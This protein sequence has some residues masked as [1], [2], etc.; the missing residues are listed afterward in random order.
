MPASVRIA[1]VQQTSVPGDVEANVAA[2]ADLIG[3]AARQGAQVVLFPELS[4]TGYELELVEQ[5]PGLTLE[6]GDVRID[7]LIA[8]C[9]EVE[10]IAIVG[11]PVVH[12][13]AR[14]LAALVLDGDGVRDVYGKRRVHSSESHLFAPGEHAVTLEVGGCRL[15]LAVCA[16]SREPAHAADCRAAGADAYLVGAFHVGGE[17]QQTAKRMAARARELGL[18]VALAEH[19]GDTGTGTGSACGGSGFWAPG[20]EVIAQLGDEA[21]AVATAEITTV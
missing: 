6:P 12:D 14:L 2:H 4:L 13:D 7:P 9:R 5:R 15:A 16:D 19:A 20:G 1:V 11:A 3:K 21:P 8:A 18:W 10:A 17:G